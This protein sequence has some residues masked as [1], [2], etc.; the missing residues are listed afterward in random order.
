MSIAEFFNQGGYAFFVW[1]SYG[2]TAVLMIAEIWYLR[3]HRHT[4]VKRVKR[5]IRL[6]ERNP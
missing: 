5:L 1:S 6:E 2:L 4:I 3:R